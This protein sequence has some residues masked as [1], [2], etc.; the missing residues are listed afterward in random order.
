MGSWH[1]NLL[2]LT[3]MIVALTAAVVPATA[4]DEAYTAPRLVGTENPD[5]NGIWQ[6]LNT[7]NWDLRP[8]AAAPA[9]LPEL[10]GALGAVPAGQGVIEGDEIP[11]QPW[12]VEQQ[13]ANFEGRLTRPTVLT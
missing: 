1:R 5:L 13:R 9:P 12:A 7:A 3:T 2:V 6:A 8:H 4:Q 10:L 11:Y